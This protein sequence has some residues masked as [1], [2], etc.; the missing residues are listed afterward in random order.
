MAKNNRDDNLCFSAVLFL[1]TDDR[2]AVS[3]MSLRELNVQIKA[4]KLREILTTIYH[5]PQ[6][7]K[8]NQ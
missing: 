3:E 6:Q 2:S 8:L 5:Q 7:I 1:I 4:I